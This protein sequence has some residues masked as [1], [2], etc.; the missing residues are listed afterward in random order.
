MKLHEIADKVATP[1]EKVQGGE[2]PKA[3]RKA[4]KK[5]MRKLKKK[6]KLPM[7][8]RKQAESIEV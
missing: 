4:G 7:F 2:H 8:L 3:V 5:L 6:K 1:Y